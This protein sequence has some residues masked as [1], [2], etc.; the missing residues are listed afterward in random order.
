MKSLK[1][2][3]N[4]IRVIFIDNG[5][6]INKNKHIVNTNNKGYNLSIKL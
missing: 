1:I 6:H 5:T 3:G 2:I 4:N